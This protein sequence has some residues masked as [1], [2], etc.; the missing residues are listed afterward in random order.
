[1]RRCKDRDIWI[2]L[3]FLKVGLFHLMVS[4]E[5]QPFFFV[6]FSD[7][8]GVLYAVLFSFFIIREDD[9]KISHFK[10]WS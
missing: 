8:R 5:K 10:I 2:L 4:R 1:M 9:S 6:T 3:Y 7:Y